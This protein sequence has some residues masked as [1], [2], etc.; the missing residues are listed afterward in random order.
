M[1]S[2]PSTLLRKR[3]KTYKTFQT[4]IKTLPTWEQILLTDISEKRKSYANLETHLKMGSVLWIAT[5]SGV[6]GP[7]RYVRWVIAT[8]TQVLWEGKGQAQSNPDLIESL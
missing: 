6:K 8:D 4:Y 1:A 3:H 7:L 2:T 5:D